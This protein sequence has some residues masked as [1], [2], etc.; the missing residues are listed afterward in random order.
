MP[1]AS[2]GQWMRP[3]APPEAGGADLRIASAAA[4]VYAAGVLYVVVLHVIAP[5]RAGP[6][7]LTQ[8]VEPYL[9]L[10]A[11]IVLPLALRRWGRWRLVLAALLVVV[12]CVRLG[13]TWIS[14]PSTAAATDSLSV[15]AWNLLA[16][17]NGGERLR[18]GLAGVE[19]DLVGLAELQVETAK[20][21][22]SDTELSGR[23]PH[24]VLGLNGSA[25]DVGLISRHP[26]VE[27]ERW[28][29][30]PLIR[31]VVQPT[32]QAPITVFVGHPLSARIDT[33]A[34]L[35]VG[36]DTTL[37]D[38]RIA[39]IRSFV[40][41]E[42]TANRS[43]LLIGDF[44]VTEHEPAY[45]VLAAGLRDAHLEV[46]LGPGFTWRPLRL[47]G[48]PFGLLRIDYILTSPDFAI[49][50]VG[51]DCSEP[52]DHCRISAVVWRPSLGP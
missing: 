39:T 38:Q 42:L 50:S 7:A 33:V 2:A 12:T 44:N 24:R 15:V 52:S 1:A 41:R 4:A 21:I 35:P 16:G 23:F 13:P 40:D 26:I 22:N 49:S 30:P 10:A 31:A 43:V 48:F 3:S 34:D 18:D 29:D 17:P 6:T 19:L 5:Q 9:I 36:V 8:I 14:F 28:T 32:G 11:L 37:R 45:S 20:V 27:Q 51:L 25:L 47:A 46:G